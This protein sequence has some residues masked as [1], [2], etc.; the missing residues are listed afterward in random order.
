MRS[1]SFHEAL[2]P[3]WQC[4]GCAAPWPCP[5]RR[6]QLRA[7]EHAYAHEHQ[8]DRQSFAIGKPQSRDLAGIALQGDHTGAKADIGAERVIGP[9][10]EVGDDRGYRP[11]HGTFAKLE[12]MH[13]QAASGCNRRKLQADE[14][15]PDDRNALRT[16]EPLPQQ[17]SVGEAAQGQHTVQ[18]R[19]FERKQPLAAPH[20]EHEVVVGERRA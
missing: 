17:L 15:R 13:L 12:D 3:S 20:R 11:A 4:A 1:V 18:S 2:R 8:V 7:G 10:V 6:R 19:A 16:V 9:R 14:A 5:T